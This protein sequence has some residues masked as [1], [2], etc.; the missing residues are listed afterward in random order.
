[1]IVHDVTVIAARDEMR[2]LLTEQILIDRDPERQHVQADGV[3]RGLVRALSLFGKEL[4]DAYDE[5]E[6]W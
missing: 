5:L 4:I 3:L 1:M 6:K 2:A